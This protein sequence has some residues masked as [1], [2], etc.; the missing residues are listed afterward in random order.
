MS[1]VAEWIRQARRA[2]AEEMAW[3]PRP[4]LARVH[5]LTAAGLPARLFLPDTTGPARSG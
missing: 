3:L 4:A 5:D 1:T 2:H